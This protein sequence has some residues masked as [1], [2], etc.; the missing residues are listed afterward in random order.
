MLEQSGELHRREEWIIIIIIIIYT[1]KI[2]I[3]RIEGKLLVMF[4]VENANADKI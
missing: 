1:P 4:K 3:A 2:S